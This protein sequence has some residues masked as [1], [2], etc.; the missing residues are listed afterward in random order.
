MVTL[1]FASSSSDF[2]DMLN[3]CDDKLFDWSWS[4]SEPL[5]SSSSLS[6]D[7]TLSEDLSADLS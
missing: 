2:D 7:L 4:S 6:F 1:Q 3:E 5:H